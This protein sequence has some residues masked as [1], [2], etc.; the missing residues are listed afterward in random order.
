VANPAWRDDPSP[1]VET[2]VEAHLHPGRDLHLSLDRMA[3]LDPQDPPFDRD[4]PRRL[5]RRSEAVNTTTDI[6]R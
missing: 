1:I 3:G 5:I 6:D 4:P 2:R